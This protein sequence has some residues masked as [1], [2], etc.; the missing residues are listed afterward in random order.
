MRKFIVFIFKNLF[1]RL[2]VLLIVGFI[3]FSLFYLLFCPL[4]TFHSSDPFAGKNW[5]NPYQNLDMQEFQQGNF[6]VHSNAWGLATNGRKNSSQEIYQTYKSFGH[7]SIGISDYQ[8]INKYN[9]EDT[10]YISVYEH[11]YNFKKSHQLVLGDN[12]TYPLD[13]MFIQNIHCKQHI[14]NQLKSKDNLVVLAHPAH[15]GGYR[16]SEIKLLS[17]Y[18]LFEVLNHYRNSENYWDI[19]L[20]SGK[21]VYL[22]ANDDSHDVENLN[23][24]VRHFTWIYTPSNHKD[25]VLKALK[26]GRAIGVDFPSL[27][28]EGVHQ[29][30]N[31]LKQIP[32]ILYSNLQKDSLGTSLQIK[33]KNGKGRFEFIGD[34]GRLLASVSS[35]DSASFLLPNDPTISYVRVKIY[36]D[37][38]TV[39]Y[40]NPT[41]RYHENI[42]GNPITCEVAQGRTWTLRIVGVVF[43]ILICLNILNIYRKMKEKKRRK[44]SKYR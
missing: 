41:V 44:K 30:R 2:P 28:G 18:D 43:C 1:F 42:P 16:A 29:K 5:L 22:L 32:S 14:I 40:L 23:E 39:F 4:F 38:G 10:A 6:H 36:F 7:T 35:T 15:W 26:S 8:K 27:Q 20:S 33:I 17:N 13:F 9:N 34:E 12:E 31:R 21:L 11:G 3:I 24:T 25:S 37:N 19:A